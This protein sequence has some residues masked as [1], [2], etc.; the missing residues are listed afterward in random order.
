MCGK[1]NARS[2]AGRFKV[3]D[4]HSSHHSEGSV[5]IEEHFEEHHHQS[6][7]QF[8]IQQNMGNPGMPPMGQP[9][10]APMGMGMGQP[11]FM[12]PNPHQQFG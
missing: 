6:G 1:K 10:M 2:D 7:P 4:D 8:P 5:H 11:G 9:G 3:G 12:P